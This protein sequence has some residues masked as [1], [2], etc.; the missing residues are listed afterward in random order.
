MNITVYE[1]IEHAKALINFLEEYCMELNHNIITAPMD[2]INDVRYHGLPREYADKVEY[3]Y[4][5]NA[6]IAQC[7]INDIKERHIPYWQAV[8]KDL[9]K[10]L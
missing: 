1:E 4:R 10:S 5:E 3:N 7:M 8:I 2:E 6:T 9:E